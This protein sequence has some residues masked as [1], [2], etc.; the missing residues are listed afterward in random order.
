AADEN[1]LLDDL[2]QA[3]A[4]NHEQVLVGIP[5]GSA[6]RVAIRA[7]HE[8]EKGAIERG[9]LRA[10]GEAPVDGDHGSEGFFEELEVL[11]GAFCRLADGAAKVSAVALDVG[12]DSEAS[13]SRAFKKIVGVAPATWRGSAHSRAATSPSSAPARRVRRRPLV[14]AAMGH[15]KR[16]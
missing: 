4:G 9:L 5:R 15:R 2:S 3:L 6:L 10:A 11:A 1:Q 13:F 12:H 7:R 14:P 8:I 16:N